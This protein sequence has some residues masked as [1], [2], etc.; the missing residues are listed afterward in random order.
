MYEIQDGRTNERVAACQMRW[1]NPLAQGKLKVWCETRTNFSGGQGPK[2]ERHV[3]NSKIH[4]AVTFEIHWAACA[5]DH[6]NP[7]IQSNPGGMLPNVPVK[8]FN[9][10]PMRGS[11]LQHQVGPSRPMWSPCFGSISDR[12]LFPGVCSRRRWSCCLRC[13]CG[14]TSDGCHSWTSTRA[15]SHRSILGRGLTV[16]ATETSPEPVKFTLRPFVS[17]HF[18]AHCWVSCTRF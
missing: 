6:F 16:I 12:G 11:S 15:S 10:G 2:I 7:D 3:P 1:V 17:A 14:R 8:D 18:P 9:A 4:S 5:E 13:P